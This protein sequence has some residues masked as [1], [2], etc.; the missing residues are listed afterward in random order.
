[1]SLRIICD[2]SLVQ[3]W[4]TERHGTPARRRDTENDLCVLFDDTNAVY[5]SIPLEEFLE[6][7]KFHKLSMLIKQEA[8]NTFH[9]IYQH[10]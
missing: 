3:R 10:G 5:D 2:P 6:T 7:M 4:I 9:K 8:G 1:M